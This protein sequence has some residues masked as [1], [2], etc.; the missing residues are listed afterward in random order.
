MGAG[1]GHGQ[2]AVSLT[3]VLDILQGALKAEL[4]VGGA[5]VP[6]DERLGGAGGRVDSGRVAHGAGLTQGQAG[7]LGSLVGEAVV[8][9]KFV[10]VVGALHVTR[11]HPIVVGVC[12]DSLSGAEVGVRGC[13]LQ[14]TVVVG[15]QHSRGLTITDLSLDLLAVALNLSAG[16]EVDEPSFVVH[17]KVDGLGEGGLDLAGGLKLACV[18]L[19]VDLQAEVLVFAVGGL[20]SSLGVESAAI[21]LVVQGEA[22]LLSVLQWC[23]EVSRGDQAGGGPLVAGVGIHSLTAILEGGG[24]GEVLGDAAV[25]DVHGHGLH[26]LAWCG[27]SHTGLEVLPVTA[28]IK[29]EAWV[30]VLFKWSLDADLGI[31]LLALLCVLSIGLELFVPS[32]WGGKGRPSIHVTVFFLENYVSIDHVAIPSS[33]SRGGEVIQGAAVVD[34]ERTLSVERIDLTRG[35]KV[36]QGAFVG[37]VEASSFIMLMWGLE[38]AL[39]GEATFCVL[40]LQAVGVAS[41][42]K[43]PGAREI[44]ILVGVLEIMRGCVAPVVDLE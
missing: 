6:V 34:A 27:K 17:L 38:T 31:D 40:V 42:G 5:R 41:H 44:H 30:Y 15:L 3:R 26:V 28:V 10:L 23:A 37:Q 12:Q 19:V 13:D 18:T 14:E 16:L 4:A 25:V 43:I 2:L 1:D 32:E 24:R 22:K 8:T 36:V 29:G 20:N 11:P 33:F 39:C 35:G 7:A 9:I 21:V